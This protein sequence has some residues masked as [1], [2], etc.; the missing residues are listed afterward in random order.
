[1]HTILY[2]GQKFVMSGW[3]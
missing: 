2:H 1:M 3:A